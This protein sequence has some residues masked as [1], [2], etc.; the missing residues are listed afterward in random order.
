MSFS[1]VWTLPHIYIV[2]LAHPREIG[3][4]PERKTVHTPVC[5][6]LSSPREIVHTDG[7]FSLFP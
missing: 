7:K 4:R 5:I 2:S 1:L 6:P 3:N